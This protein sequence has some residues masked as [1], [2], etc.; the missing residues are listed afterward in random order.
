MKEEQ[1]IQEAQ[2]SYPYHYIPNWGDNAF[3]QT[4]HWSWGFRYL[5]GMKVV[6][7]QLSE[8]SFD[9]LVDVGCGDGRFLREVKKR[10]PAKEVLGIDYSERAINLAQA[11]N[12]NLRY[13]RRDIITKPL[14][15]TFDVA[16]LIEVVEHIRPDQVQQF[17]RQVHAALRPG[18]R[19]VLTVP[20]VNM[21]VQDKHFQHFDSEALR[22]LL[23]PLFEELKFI[24]FDSRS[25]LLKVA[26]LFMGGQGNHFVLTNTMLSRAFLR[27]YFDKFLYEVTESDCG[28]IAVTGRTRAE[29]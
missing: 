28:R 17:I 15:R 5:G 6:L 20:H 18:G 10:H 26:Q 4:Q 13:E 19:L 29:H 7:D 11:M 14:N 16:T 22:N 27:M 21:P 9:S 12:P 3:S 23:T 1:N 24:P 2:Y 25:K 8:I